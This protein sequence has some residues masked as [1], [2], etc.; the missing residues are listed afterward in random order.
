M[1]LG[2]S[3]TSETPGGLGTCIR[4]SETPRTSGT[5]R[6]LGTPVGGLELSRT[7]ETTWARELKVYFRGSL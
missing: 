1:G 7:P 5:P 3:G 4:T 6:G 2:T